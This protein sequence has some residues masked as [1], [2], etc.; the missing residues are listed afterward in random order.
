[1]VLMRT[2]E[3]IFLKTDEMIK[4][5]TKEQQSFFFAHFA[6]LKYTKR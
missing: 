4:A 1:M 5:S 6:K 2:K 3:I